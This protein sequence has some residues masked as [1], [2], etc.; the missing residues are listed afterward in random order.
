[1]LR[2]G[3][4]ISIISLSWTLLAGSCAIALGAEDGSLT[5]AAFGAIGLL[6]AVG[7]TAL[8]VHFKHALR[9]ETISEGHERMALRVVTLGMAGVGTGTI[10]ISALR[11]A[12]PSSDRSSAA[13]IALAAASIGVLAALAARKRAVA[14]RVP[15]Q[16]LNADGWLS[17]VGAV[18][19]GFT[20]AGTALTA[21]Y[22]WW[23]LDPVAALAVAV[24][25][26]AVSVSL[27]S[28]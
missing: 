8:V 16:A 3:L 21:A 11:L 9:H 12:T 6:D 18:L 22:G 5:L 27:I 25:A 17:A 26:I 13:G 2:A 10:A 24:G 23:W 15:S 28:N 4:R 7:S 1:M 14:R 20:L 19:A